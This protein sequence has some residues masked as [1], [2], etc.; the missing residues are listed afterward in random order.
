MTER[1]RSIPNNVA[2]SPITTD[3]AT[4]STA[5]ITSPLS[6]KAIVSAE[7]AENV[8]K[9][10][11]NPVASNNR[12]VESIESGFVM[13]NPTNTPIIRHPITFTDSVPKGNPDED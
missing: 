4:Y 5:V 10:P 8:V 3:T 13:D 6:S 1:T 12:L 7:N 2:K 11:Q 9:P